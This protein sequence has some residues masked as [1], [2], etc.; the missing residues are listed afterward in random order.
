MKN[1]FY[2][3][4]DKTVDL[5]RAFYASKNTTFSNIIIAG[6]AD[7][8]S[9]FKESNEISVYNSQF[10]LRYPFWHVNDLD[11]DSCSFASTSRAAFWYC[12]QIHGD[13]LVINGVKAFRES[14]EISVANSNINSEEV[15]W[16]C[17]DIKIRQCNIN[18]FYAFFNSQNIT[19]NQMFFTGKYSF[20]YAENV[21][22]EGSNLDTKDAFWH[23]KNVTVRGSTIKGEYLG[24][25]S[26]GLTLVNCHIQGTQPLCYCK[27]LK[28][29][30]CTFE[31]CDL[32]FEYSEVDANI[33]GTI[34]SIK[35]PLK[36]NVRI[37]SKPTL[38]IDQN[39]RSNGEFKITITK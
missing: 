24:W 33:I 36:G 21:N 10:F 23:S 11:I 22:I 4:S 6:I 27:N 2:T 35:N 5:E 15:F 25:Y 39:D 16:N 20:Q 28:I 14:N 8:E 1:R 26:E 34:D 37:K 3:I 9:A 17:S 31:E 30:D 38:I 12:N 13:R 7:G 32:A 29:V 18:G 19:V